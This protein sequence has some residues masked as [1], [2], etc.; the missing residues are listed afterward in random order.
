M[1]ALASCLSLFI[2]VVCKTLYDKERRR[3]YMDSIRRQVRK[4]GNSNAL[5]FDRTLMELLNVNTYDYI[6]IIPTGDGLLIKKDLLNNK[7]D[8]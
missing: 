1:V 7:Q 6:L 5:I 3:K 4:T 8:K 2:S